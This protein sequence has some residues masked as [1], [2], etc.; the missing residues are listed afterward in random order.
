MERVLLG[1]EETNGLAD[2]EP[3]GETSE[4]LDG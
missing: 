3:D 1:G 4:T 2:R